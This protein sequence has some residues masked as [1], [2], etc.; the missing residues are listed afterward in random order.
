MTLDEFLTEHKISAES[1]ALNI[2]RTVTTVS[3]LRN[4]H[5]VPDPTTACRIYKA[6]NGLVEPNDF[7]GFMRG[8]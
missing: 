4:G 5:H 8:R 7:Y 1:F 2:R 6:T 3:R